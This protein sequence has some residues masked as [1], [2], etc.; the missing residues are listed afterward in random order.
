MEDFGTLAVG[1][2]LF[3]VFL[4]A[5]VWL[6]ASVLWAPFAAFVSARR[7]HA[8]GLNAAYFGLVG[9]LHSV[10]LLL[11]WIYLMMRLSGNRLHVAIVFVGYLGVSSIWLLSMWITY[12]F[13][14][15]RSGALAIL[16][17]LG[18]V[19]LMTVA[20][21]QV[22]LTYRKLNAQEGSPN[23]PMH[24]EHTLSDLWYIA[25]FGVT[26]AQA[27]VLAYAVWLAVFS[28]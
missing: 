4:L 11:P 27:L 10:A 24:Y 19:V 28:W 15:E 3:F 26:Y 7:A 2:V 16:T 20:L 8:V 14:S 12:V 9:A 5:G 17:T 13:M 18:S 23:G 21:T 6:P 22:L 1:I 25:P